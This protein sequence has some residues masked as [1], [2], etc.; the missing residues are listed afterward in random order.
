MH[1]PTKSRH[2]WGTTVSLW[3]IQKSSGKKEIL[4]VERILGNSPVYLLCLE[5]EMATCGVIIYRFMATSQST[6]P[7]S[8]YVLKDHNEII[9]CKHC[10]NRFFLTFS[11]MRTVTIHKHYKLLHDSYKTLKKL[12]CIL[13]KLSW[14][15]ERELW[16]TPSG[17][18]W[19]RPWPVLTGCFA[20]PQSLQD[21][22][23]KDWAHLKSSKGQ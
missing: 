19:E 23:S 17:R 5:G 6:F 18:S 7:W 2:D 15:W 12:T 1:T 13:R 14:W 3:N 20:W 16:R 22:Q 10:W 11:H 8:Y 21:T 4:P 9:A